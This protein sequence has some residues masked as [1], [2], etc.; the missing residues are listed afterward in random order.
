M[1]IGG[2]FFR[3]QC[4][5]NGEWVGGDGIDLDNPATDEI[6]GSV[7]CFGRAETARAID[8]AHAAFL[9]WRSR[10]AVERA[11]FCRR[12]FEALM[13]NQDE[14]GRLLTI[15]MGKPLAEAKG[16]IAYAAGFFRWF[17]EESRRVYGDVIPSPWLGKRVVVTKEPVGVVGSITPWNFPTAMIARKAA[18]ALA[19]GC[20]IVCKPAEKTPFSAFAYGV[21]ADD[22]GLPKGVLN[23]IT[24]PA[25]G[26]ADEMCENPK[27][28]KIT[29]P[30]STAVGKHLA[31][32]ASAYMKRIS[33]ELGGNAPFIAR[34]RS[35]LCGKA[36][37][38]RGQ[39]PLPVF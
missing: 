13:D 39:G 18:A 37:R 31:S 3:E 29:F 36:A 7:P 33:M 28:R 24:G 25:V 19:A 8:A 15:E 12:F 27:V 6:I 11:G 26:I 2:R 34:R 1:A 30:G 23:M 22:I 16:E 20:T 10:P 4:F 14:L 38:S 32:K 5:I 9:E 17:G 21:I 35:G